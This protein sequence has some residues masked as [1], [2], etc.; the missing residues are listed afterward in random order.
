MKNDSKALSFTSKLSIVGLL[1]KRSL[2]KGTH[3]E[4]EVVCEEVSW[5][6]WARAQEKAEGWRHLGVIHRDGAK[7][8]RQVKGLPEKHPLPYPS[9]SFS[10]F[11]F[12][13]AGNLEEHQD[14]KTLR[15]EIIEIKL[16]IFMRKDS[17]IYVKIILM[18]I[19]VDNV[20]QLKKRERENYLI[21]PRK[22]FQMTNIDHS[23]FSFGGSWPSL[24]M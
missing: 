5:R 22:L 23:F 24:R 8:I 12:F 19:N 13:L 6:Q 14:I 21:S 18:L 10:I 16:K 20:I 7:A 17:I 3:L 11:C 15:I 9:S 2:R 4:E 1:T